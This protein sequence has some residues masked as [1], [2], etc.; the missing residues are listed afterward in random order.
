M[1]LV[2]SWPS[3]LCVW[4]YLFSFIMWFDV[5]SRHKCMQAYMHVCDTSSFTSSLR[6]CGTFRD[7][8]SQCAAAHHFAM[9]NI[10]CAFTASSWYHGSNSNICENYIY[11]LHTM[12]GIAEQSQTYAKHYI[13]NSFGQSLTTAIHAFGFKFIEYQFYSSI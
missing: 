1:K 2:Y 4:W 7:K 11:A 3:I 8:C 6:L 13:W 9:N 10:I 5:L 12:H